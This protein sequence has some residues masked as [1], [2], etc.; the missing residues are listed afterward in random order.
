MQKLRQDINM[1][2]NL[3]VLRK[4]CGLTQ[5]QVAAQL[6][7]L[8]CGITRTIYSRYE[9]GELNIRISDLIALRKVFNCKYD[10]FFEGLE[11]RRVD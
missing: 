4:Q 2:E 6:Q 5:E 7:V 9:T 3:R 8:G 1:G 10:N 11:V